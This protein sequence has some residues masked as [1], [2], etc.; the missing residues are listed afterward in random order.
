M[1]QSVIAMRRQ[2]WRVI[3]AVPEGGDLITEL[4]ECGAEVRFLRFPVLR[5][6]CFSARGILDLGAGVACAVPRIIGEVRAIQPDVVYVNT[7]TIPWWLPAAR[8]LGVPTICHVHE[9]EAEDSRVVRTGLNLPLLAATAIISISEPATEAITLPGPRSRAHLIYN[10]VP[11]PQTSVA[12][13]PE[14]RAFRLAVI[15]RLSPRKAPHVALE[16]IALAR[17]RGR[18][19]ALDV[20]GTPF[21]GYE[22]YEQQLRERAEEDDLKGFVR[23]LGYVSPIWSTLAAVNAVLAPSLREPFGNAVVEAQ[24]ARRPVIAAAAMGH[25]ETV[26]HEE[27]GLLVAPN[28]A[29]AMAGAIERIMDDDGLRDRIAAQAEQRAIE[30][31]SLNRY[32]SQVADLVTSVAERRMS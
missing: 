3:V 26:H 6:S 10:G 22:W 15:G 9:A 27:T 11:Q 7:E 14:E 12:R 17:R 30:C 24:L 13:P 1:V 5:R 2:G 20:C 8:A 21:T 19:V 29:E 28:D 23:F 18:N 4:E 31:F 16:A 25:L 32:H